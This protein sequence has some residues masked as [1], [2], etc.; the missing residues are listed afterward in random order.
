VLG[1]YNLTYNTAN[2]TITPKA[3]SVTPN[4]ASKIYGDADPAFTGTLVG[5][6]AADGVTA[7][8]SRTGGETVAGSPYTITA[9]LS[10]A[11][12]LGNYNI[13]LNTA[14]FTITPKA[15]TVSG[16]TANN[17]PFDHNAIATLNL[18]GAALVGVVAPD[19]ITFNTAGATGTFPTHLVGGPYP[20]TVSGLSISGPAVGNYTLTP[21]TP[22]ASITGWNLSGFLQPVGIPNTYPGMGPGVTSSTTWNTIKGGQTVPLKFQIFTGVGGAEITNVSEVEGFWLWS[23]PCT[24]GVETPVDADFATT[25]STALRYEGGQFIQ[26]WQ[27]PKGANK[28]YQVTMKTKD[29]SAL[30]AYFKAK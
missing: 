27:T 6:L 16:I 9:V 15:L 22:T 28:C 1:N 24:A 11:G 30:T 23:L 21:P 17:K 4:A 10:P 12:V 29:G 13:T 25:G 20:V 2:F 14:N 8:Y 26:N 19:V 3:A 18:G 5:F 7:T